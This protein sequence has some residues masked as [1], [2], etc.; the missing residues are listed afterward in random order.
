MP[1]PL[2]FNLS[3]IYLREWKPTNTQP[4]NMF[5]TTQPLAPRHAQLPLPSEE[6]MLRLLRADDGMATDPE[7]LIDQSKEKRIELPSLREQVL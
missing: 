4:T 6:Q 2:S 1:N 5:N 7:A 3:L